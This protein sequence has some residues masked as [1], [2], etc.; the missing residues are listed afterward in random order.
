[1]FPFSLCLLL[2]A[3]SFSSQADWLST[4]Q[5]SQLSSPKD[6]FADQNTPNPSIS[7]DDGIA[8]S[9]DSP[10]FP[11][12]VVP[13][14]EAVTNGQTASSESSSGVPNTINAADQQSMAL[15]EEEG[16]VNLF[17]WNLLPALDG[18][19]RWIDL[20]SILDGIPSRTM[21]IDYPSPQAGRFND[22]ERLADPKYPECDGGKYAMCCSVSAPMQPL[23]AH[24]I[25]KR[26]RCF[27]CMLPWFLLT[28]YN[29]NLFAEPHTYHSFF[30]VLKSCSTQSYHF[31]MG[32]IL[33]V[34]I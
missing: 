10:D 34:L 2:I 23:A 4:P 19:Q 14:K 6:E 20:P 31:A 26:R 30:P 18:F 24:N 33:G 15:R 29:I 16:G 13:N 8:Y 7:L 12:N 1:M 5:D 28:F 27:L 25:H 32:L 9:F 3:L 21:G 11:V 22:N 17:P